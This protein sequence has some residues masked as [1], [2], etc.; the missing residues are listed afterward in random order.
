MEIILEAIRQVVSDYAFFSND[1]EEKFND[2]ICQCD[3]DYGCDS[4]CDEG[5]DCD[6]GNFGE[7]YVQ[8]DDCYM[9]A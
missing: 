5:C 7:G 4:Y 6:C 2:E 8:N 1:I 3:D 9:G